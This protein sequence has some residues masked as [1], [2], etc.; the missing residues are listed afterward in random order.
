MIRQVAAKGLACHPKHA[1]CF[2]QSPN[3]FSLNA[4]PVLFE[5]GV[6]GEPAASPKRP[7]ARKKKLRPGSQKNPSFQAA[8]AGLGLLQ[9]RNFVFWVMNRQF[10]CSLPWPF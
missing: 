7:D 6:G 9:H 10:R 4:M 8:A 5:P 1:P 3:Q 2:D